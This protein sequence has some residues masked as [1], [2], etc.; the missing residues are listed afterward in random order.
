MP[1]S[2]PLAGQAAALACHER[3]NVECDY[4]RRRIRQPWREIAGVVGCAE[5]EE[6]RVAGL[7]G[8]ESVVIDCGDCVLHAGREGHEEELEDGELGDA[9]VRV[10]ILIG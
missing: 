3:A 9:K 5:R 4:A 2:L 1:R 8:V 10:P 6:D 7:R